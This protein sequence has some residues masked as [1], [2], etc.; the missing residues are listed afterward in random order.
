M[1][2]TC[3]NR[4]ETSDGR[5]RHE[6]PPENDGKVSLCSLSPRLLCDESVKHVCPSLSYS[7][8]Q[9][10]LKCRRSYLLGRLMGFRRWPWTLSSPIVMGSL[11]DAYRGFCHLTDRADLDRL[12]KEYAL[13]RSN[14][15]RFGCKFKWLLDIDDPHE[16][17]LALVHELA[18]KVY[19]PD[20][21]T[22]ARIVGVCMA[23]HD[24]DI[25]PPEG[26]FVGS[27]IA[28]REKIERH[29]CP[30]GGL[31]LRGVFDHL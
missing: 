11:W 12:L 25:A 30:D 18:A 1:E 21:H 6:I 7:A 2:M 19:K 29:G 17:A 13:G 26:E 3:H 31:V 5:C 14:Y 22:L 15:R 20:P 9:D 8:A 27:Q 10:W 28:W 16:R 24:L 4:I 23:Y